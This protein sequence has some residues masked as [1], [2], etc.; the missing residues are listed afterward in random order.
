M[1]MARVGRRGEEAPGFRSNPTGGACSTVLQKSTLEYLH[2]CNA[3]RYVARRVEKV[4]SD[5]VSQS[6]VTVWSNRL[7]K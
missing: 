1:I 4:R 2:H 6:I 7:F 5:S 3:V